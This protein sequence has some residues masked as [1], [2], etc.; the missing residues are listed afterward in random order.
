MVKRRK[1]RKGPELLSKFLDENELSLQGFADVLGCSKAMVGFLKLGS[2]PPGLE[3][4]CKIE[5]ATDGKIRPDS[6]ID[7]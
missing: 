6:W 1:K 3:L 2:A 7:L 5:K 4:A